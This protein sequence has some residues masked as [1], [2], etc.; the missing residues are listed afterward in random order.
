MLLPDD[1][2]RHLFRFALP[3][4]DAV[5]H[6]P[7]QHRPDDDAEGDGEQRAPI[8]QRVLQLLADD[9]ERLVNRH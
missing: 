4:G 9:D 7:D 8:A 5:H 1:W 2:N 3:I 6:E